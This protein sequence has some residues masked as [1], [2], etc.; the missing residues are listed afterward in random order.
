M[1]FESCLKGR[2]GICCFGCS[3]SL[4]MHLIALLTFAEVALIGSIFC[5]ELASGIFNL[6]V[7]TWLA[8]SLFRT[9]SYFAMCCDSIAR[10]KMH[11]WVVLVTT[12]IEAA[13]F[14]IMNMGLFDGSNT[15]K[16]FMVLEAWGLGTSMQII[17]IEVVSFIHLCMFVYFCAV[18]FE[19]YTFAR[20][21]PTMI[22][23]EHKNQ[24]AAD[25]ASA[26]AR[27]RAE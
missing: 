13:L 6:K 1:C 22:D 11:M 7:F 18:T 3:T 17:V 15:E 14:T 10:R 8:I 12:M 24:A 16:A 9:L 23:R 4:G 2:T 25:K 26:A 27:K 5:S 21:D 20:D 19:Y